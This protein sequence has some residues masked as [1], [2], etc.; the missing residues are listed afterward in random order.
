MRDQMLSSKLEIKNN[1]KLY[2]RRNFPQKVVYIAYAL[3]LKQTT[4]GSG[5]VTIFFAVKWGLL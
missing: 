5:E 3:S 1:R 2:E 4:S